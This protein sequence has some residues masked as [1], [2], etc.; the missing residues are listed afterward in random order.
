MPEQPPIVHTVKVM[1]P[2]KTYSCDGLG[3]HPDPSWSDKHVRWCCYKYGSFCPKTVVDKNIYH[4]VVKTQPVRVPVPEPMPTH[5][6]IVKTIHHTYHV[7]SPP[8]YVHVPVPGPTVVKPVVVPESVPVP[9]PQ[10]PQVIN[11]KKPYTVHVP[12][13]NHYVHVPVPSPPHI[14]TKYHTQWNTVVDHADSTYDCDTG[15]GDWHSLWSHAKQRWCC[16]HKFVGCPGTWHGSG[17][18]IAS[19]DLIHS[20]WHSGY[21][22]ASFHSG[23][24]GGS[25]HGSGTHSWSSTHFGDD[26]LPLKK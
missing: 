15:A 6:P 10:P 11:V 14:V 19:G 2:A 23:A 12:G 25:W 22:G 4:T 5:A 20:G 7:P 17:S 3:E 13:P 24:I 26:A 18:T 16:S 1:T 8:Q 9:V 21:S